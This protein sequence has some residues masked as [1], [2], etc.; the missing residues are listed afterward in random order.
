[1]RNSG[2]L[3]IPPI[4]GSREKAFGYAQLFVPRTGTGAP[5]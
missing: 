5:R 2:L 1:M 3:V 4:P